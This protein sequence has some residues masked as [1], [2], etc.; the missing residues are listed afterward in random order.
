[1]KDTATKLHCHTETQKL[2]RRNAKAIKRQKAGVEY[3]AWL[4]NEVRAG[5][6]TAARA[7]SLKCQ[8]DAKNK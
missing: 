2:Q 3:S 5:R 4:Q 6:L 8:K 7:F 1:M